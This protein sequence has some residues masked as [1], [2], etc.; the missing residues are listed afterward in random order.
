[1]DDPPYVLNGNELWEIVH[2]FPK[3][4]NGPFEYLYGYGQY[5]NWNKRAIF[6]DLPYWKH[7]LLRHNL[8]IIYTHRK[9][10]F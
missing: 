2:D 6:W 5:H 9:K 10:L 7:N 1:M 3:V 8:D 4:T